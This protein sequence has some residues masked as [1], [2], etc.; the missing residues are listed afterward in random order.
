MTV[1]QTSSH[2]RNRLRLRPRTLVWLFVAGVST[3]AF[4][5]DDPNVGVVVA[6]PATVGVLW[7]ITDRFAIR[8]DVFWSWASNESTTTVTSGSPPQTVA[9]ESS[10]NGY[11][12]TYGVSGLVTLKQQESLRLYVGGRAAYLRSS[13]TFHNPSVTFPGGVVTVNPRK[14]RS[15]GPSFAG[16]FGGQY[17]LH[18]RF[19]I[20]GEAGLG[21]QSSETSTTGEPPLSGQGKSVNGRSG[22]GVIFFF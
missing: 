20:F 4:S 15:T 19:A 13:T 9:F 21:Y 1:A 22:V 6:Y 11:N 10:S 12:V 3:P 14:S 17:A 16:F 7:Q 8:P 18:R 5:Q 2:V